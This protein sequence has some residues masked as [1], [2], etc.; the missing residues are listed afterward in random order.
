MERIGVV[1]WNQE[2]NIALVQ[3]WCDLGLHATLLS[4]PKVVRSRQRGD[5]YFDAARTL[6]LAPSAVAA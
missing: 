5:V 6:A 2:T 3:A 4:P 1:G